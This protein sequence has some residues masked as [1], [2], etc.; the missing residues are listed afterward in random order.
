MIGKVNLPPSLANNQ[1][2]NKIRDYVCK[3]GPNSGFYS[4]ILFNKNH[5]YYFMNKSQGFP[6]IQFDWS[7]YNLMRISAKTIITSG[8]TF[9]K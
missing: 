5:E 7:M 3:L 4:C 8:I 9:R 1:I 2:A 6:Y